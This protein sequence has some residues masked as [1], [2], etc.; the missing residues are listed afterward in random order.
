MKTAK[1]ITNSKSKALLSISYRLVVVRTIEEIVKDACIISKKVKP[2]LCKQAIDTF[3]EIVIH[4]LSAKIFNPERACA[5]LRLCPKTW[6]TEIL[7]D[8]IQEVLKDKPNT[9][10]PT[11]TKR[12]TYKM[13]HISDLHVDL[14]YE[15]VRK[16]LLLYEIIGI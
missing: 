10:Q 13:M 8:Y 11:P 1:R 16:T 3:G 7:E 5:R 12:N 9:P 2:L 4:S 15:V 14:E 6:E